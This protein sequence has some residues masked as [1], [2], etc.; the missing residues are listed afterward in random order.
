MYRAEVEARIDRQHPGQARP[1][2]SSLFVLAVAA[3]AT[4]ATSPGQ[5][6][7]EAEAG[8][9]LAI[10]SKSVVTRDIEIRLDDTRPGTL[11]SG[12]LR[13]GLRTVGDLSDTYSDAIRIE[14]QPIQGGS[15]LPP[16]AAGASSGAQVALPVD[17]CADGCVLTYR[18]AFSARRE[19]GPGAV[20]RFVT[21][22]RFVYDS[23]AHRPPT[24]ALAVT[25]E[26]GQMPPVAVGWVLLAAVSGLIGGVRLGRRDRRPTTIGLAPAGVLV[27]VLVVGAAWPL[28]GRY[29]TAALVFST[30]LLLVHAGMLTLG[31][32]RWRAG[33]PWIL[34]LAAFSTVVLCGLWLAWTVGMVAVLSRVELAVIVGVLGVI[35]GT[36]LGQTW[37]RHEATLEGRT[38]QATAVVVSQ[39]LLMAGLTFVSLVAL[40]RTGGYETTP[41]PLGVVPLAAAALVGWGTLRWFVGSGGLMLA[42][43]LLLLA[44]GLLGSFV[45]FSAQAGMFGDP[46]ID[47]VDVMVVI[48]VLAALVGVFAARH[49][50]RRR[51]FR[52]GSTADVP[53]AA[54]ASP[55]QSA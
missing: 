22:V 11:L 26:G 43:N 39:G 50:L 53:D 21:R 52:E 12:E 54:D 31:I 17:D 45:W 29:V 16:A 30:A 34:G 51:S 7:L 35:S 8:S 24:D 42:I 46:G 13:V 36:V 14:I 6:E 55:E 20:I 1:R 3:L 41:D 47:A 2:R 15:A 10:E 4:I 18:I 48:E 28:T 40:I 49:P 25:I 32:R 44:I 5:P 27:A 19:I 33:Q 9:E 37:D 23:G 38:V